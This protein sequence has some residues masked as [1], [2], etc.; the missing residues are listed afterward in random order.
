VI[1]ILNKGSVFNFI[2][3]FLLSFVY[4]AFIFRVL[5][6]FVSYA[7]ICRF[8][9]LLDCYLFESLYFTWRQKESAVETSC[10]C[11][12]WR[13]KESRY[14]SMVFRMLHHCLRIIVYGKFSSLCGPRRF[15]TVFTTAC[16]WSLPFFK[17]SMQRSL[18]PGASNVQLVKESSRFCER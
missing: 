17:N 8:L 18:C 12:Q 1:L 15:V 11:N 3:I 6:Y 4:A 5:N 2:T 9:V 10:L 16:H 7:W 14:I 13:W